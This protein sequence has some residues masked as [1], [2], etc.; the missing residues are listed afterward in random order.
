MKVE[1]IKLH[2]AESI[3]I[4]KPEP[5]N[6][7]FF[8]LLQNSLLV[9]A[10]LNKQRRGS[11]QNADSTIQKSMPLPTQSVA[12][13]SDSANS[14]SDF[15]EVKLNPVMYLRRDANAPLVEIGLIKAFG[16]RVSY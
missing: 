1:S 8:E 15:T 14:E 2:N 6:D 12:G 7:N 9:N 16:L 11:V 4:S 5:T 10:N 3:A 13:P